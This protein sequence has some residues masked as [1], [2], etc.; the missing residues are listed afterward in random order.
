M[1]THTVSYTLRRDYYKHYTETE[2]R[3]ILW[4]IHLQVPG[5]GTT[6]S[7]DENITH[8]PEE[9]T[10]SFSFVLQCYYDY[11]LCKNLS[12]AAHSWATALHPQCWFIDRRFTLRFSHLRRSIA[13][14]YFSTFQQKFPTSFFI[15]LYECITNIPVI[16]YSWKKMLMTWSLLDKLGQFET[17]GIM[18]VVF[19]FLNWFEYRYGLSSTDSLSPSWCGDPQSSV[20]PPPK[21]NDS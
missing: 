1:S 7:A 10:S 21:R 11:K 12:H 20:T 16:L 8:V 15:Y 9:A 2:C 3:H 4:I 14:I 5:A 17:L 6:H 19:L 13:Q 18:C